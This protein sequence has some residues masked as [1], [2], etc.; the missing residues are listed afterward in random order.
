M[1]LGKSLNHDF[2]SAGWSL[3]R[4]GALFFDGQEEKHLPGVHQFL[5]TAAREAS[6]LSFLY[7]TSFVSCLV[8]TVRQVCPAERRTELGTEGSVKS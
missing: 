3:S 4:G 7:F 8:I 2:P 6:L 5:V 1:I